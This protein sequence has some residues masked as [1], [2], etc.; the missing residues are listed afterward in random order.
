MEPEGTSFQSATAERKENR[1]SPITISGRTHSRQKR[2]RGE[3]SGVSL[4]R[5]PLFGEYVN[6]PSGVPAWAAVPLP[7]EA[8]PGG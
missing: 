8:P 4:T 6:R 2:L 3:R 1:T 5:A 7:G